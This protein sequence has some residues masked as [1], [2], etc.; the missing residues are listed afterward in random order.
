MISVVLV[1]APPLMIA[2]TM[3]SPMAWRGSVVERDDESPRIDVGILA[4]SAALRS[5]GTRTD[6]LQPA[7]GLSD[8]GLHIVH[9]ALMRDLGCAGAD[10]IDRICPS[11]RCRDWTPAVWCSCRSGIRAFVGT[12]SSTGQRTNG[13]LA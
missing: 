7:S 6:R 1:F 12:G 11:G 4:Q 2:A 13:F 9:A 10:R 3:L 8:W 5:N